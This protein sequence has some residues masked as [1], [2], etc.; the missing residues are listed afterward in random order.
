GDVGKGW[1]GDPLRSATEC[2]PYEPVDVGLLLLDGGPEFGHRR[3]EFLVHPPQVRGLG[4]EGGEF[5]GRGR[6]GCHT[7]GTRHPTSGFSCRAGIP[8]RS[9]SGRP[10]VSWP[11]PR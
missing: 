2:H 8:G 3:Q 10:F 11:P 1:F 9:P 4:P 7:S 5:G 6:F